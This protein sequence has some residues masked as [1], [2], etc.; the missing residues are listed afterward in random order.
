[1]KKSSEP[2]LFEVAARVKRKKARQKWLAEQKKALIGFV[3]GVA[4]TVV[5][6]LLIRYLTG[7]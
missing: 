2:D 7:A 1:M 3:W 5:A 6:T 4:T